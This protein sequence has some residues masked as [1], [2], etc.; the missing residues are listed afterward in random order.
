MTQD[1]VTKLNSQRAG[2]FSWLVGASSDPEVEKKYKESSSLLK[3]QNEAVEKLKVHLDSLKAE[4]QSQNEKLKHL[5]EKDGS[6]GILKRGYSSR[7]S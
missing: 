1:H 2:I 5:I 3:K 6:V 4:L 7:K